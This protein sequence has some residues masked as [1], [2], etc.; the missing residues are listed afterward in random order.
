MAEPKAR[1]D[2]I[3]SLFPWLVHWTIVDERIGGARSDTFA[4]RT[5]DGLMV[6]D[7]VPLGDHLMAKL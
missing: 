6:I 2:R 3:E 7:P 4:V 5:P 1:A